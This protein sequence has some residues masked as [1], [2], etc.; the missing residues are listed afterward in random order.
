MKGLILCGGSGTRLSPFTFALPKQ[1]CSNKLPSCYILDVLEQ[2]GL[3]GN[4][5]DCRGERG[6]IKN[7]L[8][9]GSPFK[10]DVYLAGR[11]LGTGSCGANGAPFLK[12]DDFM[13]I[14]GDNLFDRPWKKQGIFLSSKRRSFDFPYAGGG[15]AA[16]GLSRSKGS[17]IIS[18]AEKPL[19]PRSNLAIMGISLA[20]L[21]SRRLKGLPLPGEV[22]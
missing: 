14:L 11:A 21:F 5:H 8:K 20:M 22:N 10:A 6:I 4:R 12:G 1:S 17:Q 7:R 9:E 15:S 3:R 19:D 18:L 2:A 16:T 13:M